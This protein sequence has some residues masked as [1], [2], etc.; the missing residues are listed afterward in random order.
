MAER[1]MLALLSSVRTMIEIHLSHPF[2]AYYLDTSSASK[3]IPPLIAM[4]IPR[5]SL[6]HGDVLPK[7]LESIQI[8]IPAE[9]YR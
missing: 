8:Y 6:F 4:H 9:S 5:A 1:L 2:E 7:S 3:S